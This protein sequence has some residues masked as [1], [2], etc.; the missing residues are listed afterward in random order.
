MV[1]DPDGHDRIDSF[2]LVTYIPEPI[3]GFLDRLRAE[4][5][6]SCALRAHITVLPPRLLEVPVEAACDVLQSRLSGISPF[7]VE[8]AEVE[9]FEVSD[10]I[11]IAIGRGHEMLKK[12]HHD[13]NQDG[14]YDQEAFRYHPHVTLAQNLDSDQLEELSVVARRRW[15]EFTGPRS[16]SIE[17]VTFVQATR[18][19]S[20]IDLSEMSLSGVWQRPL[21]KLPHEIRLY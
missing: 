21:Q 10:V 11:Y 8:L 18:R 16:F 9:V 4:L 5:V 3:A 6:P 1:C 12:M 13:L 7:T 15:A 20:W 14:L 2:A 17:C 19:K